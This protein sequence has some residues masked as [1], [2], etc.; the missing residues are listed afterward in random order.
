MGMGFGL[1]VKS[2]FMLWNYIPYNP[3]LINEQGCV[4][5][6]GLQVPTSNH[7]LLIVIT[8]VHM[9]RI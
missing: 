3:M 4:I 8:T 1:S 7:Y 6:R 9:G 2:I 5:F